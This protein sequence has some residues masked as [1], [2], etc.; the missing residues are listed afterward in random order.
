[1]STGRGPAGNDGASVK[2][3]VSHGLTSCQTVKTLS[4]ILNVPLRGM[5]VGA[6]EKVTVPVPAPTGPDVTLIHGTSLAAVHGQSESGAVMVT[7]PT[8][9]AAG[10]LRFFG[11]IWK[12]HATARHRH[13]FRPQAFGVDALVARD[14][15]AVRSNDTPP[16]DVV[17]LVEGAHH[18]ARA[19]RLAGSQRH[20]AVRQ[21][22]TA[23]DGA[24]HLPD[25]ADEGARS[26]RH[27]G[28]KRERSAIPNA[29]SNA[30]TCRTAISNPSCPNILCSRSSWRIRS[31]PAQGR[32]PVRKPSACNRGVRGR[33]VR[34][35][36]THWYLNCHTPSIPK[37]SWT[38]AVYAQSAPGEVNLQA[39]GRCIPLMVVPYVSSSRPAARRV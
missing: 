1:M 20:L 15:P 14:Q 19:A 3:G 12:T 7:L 13:A 25:G 35:C 33:Q 18:G 23:R 2:V 28:V 39:R 26:A 16:R 34:F 8:P 6:T 37:I 17:E 4:A 32:T 10:K 36:Q 21:G 24:D 9:P 38:A 22:A 11:V 27:L 31:S 30:A 5:L 29:S